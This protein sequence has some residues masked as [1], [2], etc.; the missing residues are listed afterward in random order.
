MGTAYPM[1][2][3][4]GGCMTRAAR[5]QRL[6]GCSGDAEPGLGGTGCWR[7]MGTM[8][9][10]LDTGLSTSVE[11]PWRLRTHSRQTQVAPDVVSVTA[12][13]PV[14]GQA[15]TLAPRPGQVRPSGGPGRVRGH[16]SEKGSRPASVGTSPV[17][18]GGFCLSST[19]PFSFTR[20][21]LW[22][23]SHFWDEEGSRR[24]WWHLHQRL[25]PHRP[26]Q[27]CASLWAHMRVS[28][29]VSVAALCS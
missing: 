5:R 9:W 7:P 10:S 4:P 28:Q 26:H 22:L 21:R 6:W 18:A 27:G 17:C 23:R 12:V 20:P 8:G 13:W 1:S 25:V 19:Q 3:L 14:G 15:R 24:Q 29:T 2:K 11:W 16:P